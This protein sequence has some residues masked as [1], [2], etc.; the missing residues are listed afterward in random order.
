MGRLGAVVYRDRRDT[1]EKPD[2]TLGSRPFRPVYRIPRRSGT[3]AAKSDGS[4]AACAAVR[5]LP[6]AP[7]SVSY[8]VD[9]SRC[10][11]LVA[12]LE[13]DPERVPVSYG[14]LESVIRWL[15]D[16]T[17]LES[18]ADNRTRMAAVEM[19]ARLVLER[20]KKLG[21]N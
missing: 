15:M 21:T 3:V 12:E 19:R 6:R 5:W 2:R 18:D 4:P 9:L 7:R 17:Y 1:V 11:A 16:T 14:E 8:G 13:R 20:F 10:Q